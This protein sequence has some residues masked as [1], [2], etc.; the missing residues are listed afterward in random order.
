MKEK[1]ESTDIEVWWDWNKGKVI[2]GVIGFCIAGFLS[3]SRTGN[4]VVMLLAG[5]TGAVAA[6]IG[7]GFI[8]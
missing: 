7:A 5:G 2:A 6:Y 3:F 1:Q 8:H 4:V